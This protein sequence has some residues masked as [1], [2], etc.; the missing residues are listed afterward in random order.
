VTRQNILILCGLAIVHDSEHM[1]PSLITLHRSVVY[2]ELLCSLVYK[3]L[4][5][6]NMKGYIICKLF[7]DV[8]YNYVS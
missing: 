4:L 1:H 8:F 3:D 2:V 5:Q 7:V 6:T